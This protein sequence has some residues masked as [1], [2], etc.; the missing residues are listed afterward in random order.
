MA[1]VIRT[2]K[3]AL[4][5]SAFLASFISLFYYGVCLSRT[6]LGPRLVSPKVISPMMWDQGLCVC[7][8]CVLCGWSILIET[9]RRRQEVALFVA[10]RAA[11]TL[12]PRQYEVKYFWR[13]RAVFSV[14]V[15]LLFALAQDNPHWV[16]GMLG[17]VLEKT[18]KQ[19]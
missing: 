7:A 5:S 6:Q 18:L 16:R 10:P 15:A 3:A 4:R 1:M 11:A 9:K 19:T 8:G 13:E 12:L 17:S 14:S 2:C